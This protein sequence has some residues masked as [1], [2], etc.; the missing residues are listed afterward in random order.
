MR[1][2][3]ALVDRLGGERAFD[4]HFGFSPAGVQIAFQ[5]LNPLGHVGRRVGGVLVAI[6]TQ[7]IMQDRRVG[8]D[9]AI[10]IDDMRQNFVI[11]LD[12]VQGLARD[13]LGSGRHGGDG[14]AVVKRLLAGHHVAGDVAQVHH[15]LAGR[16]HFIGHV[17]QIGG[18]DHRFDA[19]QSLRFAG[20]DRANVG[21]GVRAAQDL[22]DQLARHVEIGAE[23]GATGDFIGP[24]GARLAGA[25]PFV[26][27]IT[28]LNSPVSWR[29][30]RR[31]CPSPPE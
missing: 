7:M 16:G 19:A 30:F 1:L 8:G 9:R 23:T 17:R 10:D 13:G 22:A 29:A 11:D 14:V 12:Q 20:V 25:N 28:H 27:L 5:E 18:G 21:M 3:V 4:D 31:R 6:G 2:D 15:D 24:V 26:R